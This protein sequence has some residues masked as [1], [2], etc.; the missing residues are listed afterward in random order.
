MFTLHK[1]IGP[2]EIKSIQNLIS[3]IQHDANTRKI[4]K[5]TVQ[6]FKTF[7]VIVM[8]FIVYCVFCALVLVL[9]NTDIERTTG[10]LYPRES[11]TREVASLDGL[12]NFVKSDIRNPTQGMR[13]KWYLDDLSRVRKTIPMPVPASYND[14]TTEHAIRDHVGTVWYDRKFFVPMSWLK[15]Q[16]VWLRFGSVHY[17]AFVV[18]N[19]PANY[20]ELFDEKQ[21]A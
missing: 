4:Y 13:D 7:I 6:C 3:I 15:N 1:N 19:V 17:E 14:I 18:S 2:E 5:C 9:L 20:P 12:W 16:R 11:E 8:I 21:C 10:M